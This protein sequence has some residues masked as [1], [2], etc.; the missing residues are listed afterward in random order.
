MLKSLFKR[1][2]ASMPAALED[3]SDGREPIIRL[4]DIKKTYQSVA[5]DFTVL[6][7]I[8]AD[9]YQGEFIGVIGKSGSGKSTLINMMTG[10]DRPSAGEVYVGKVPVHVLNEGEMSEWRGRNLG[11]VFQ[12]FQLLPMLTLLENIMLPMDFCGLYTPRQRRERALMLLNLVDMDDHANKLPSAISGGQ[13]QRVAIARALANDP[14]IIIADEPTGNLDSKTAES[15]FRMFEEMVT[16]GKTVV[17]VTHDSAL[18]R[19]VTRTLLIADGE[20]ANEWVVKALPTLSHQEMVAATRRLKPHRFKPGETI[21]QQ[22]QPG[23]LFYI[24]T[25]GMVEIAL[26]R[27]GGQDVVVNRMTAGQYFGEIELVENQRAIATVRAGNSPV[28]VVALERAAFLELLSTS[29][30]TRQAVEGIVTQRHGENV[31]A[32]ADREG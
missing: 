14:P 12:F 32:Q 31:R 5:G 16:Q 30:S 4:R 11:I 19:R 6:K 2:H 24:I 17:M 7:G 3:F 10:I 1:N 20:I 13:Q 23:D 18:A 15:V 25:R 27:P 26:K 21:I 29:E 8:D 22:G 28:E 9:F